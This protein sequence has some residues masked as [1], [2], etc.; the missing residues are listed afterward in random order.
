M[1][2]SRKTTW[3]LF[4]AALVVRLFFVA[5]IGSADVRKFLSN[6]SANYLRG[7]DNLLRYGQFSRSQAL[8]LAPDT[9]STP[10]Y[11]L[12]LAGLQAFFGDA[13]LPVVALQA[14]AGA[15]TAVLAFSLARTL[16]GSFAQSVLAGSFLVVEVVTLLL[17]NLVLTETLFILLLTGALLVL[18]HYSHSL[19]V[20]WLIAGA[21]LLGLAALTRP[22]AQFLPLIFLPLPWLV[23]QPGRRK[24]GH[25][26]L[27][28]GVF[29]AW[30]MPWMLRNAQVADVFALS[31]ISHQ[32]LVAYRAAAVLADA[33]GLS[34]E[35]AAA[36]LMALPE[37]L[38]HS[39]A[40]VMAI[41]QRRAID[42]F[43]QHPGATLKM[44]L[45]GMARLLLDPGFS[46][47]CTLLDRT[48]VST[49]CFAGEG[50]MLAGG[51]LQRVLGRFV[52]LTLFQQFMLA[53]STLI[54]AVLYIGAVL[55]A[56]RL[57]RQR[58]W[59]GLLLLVGTL[60]YFVLLS[61]GAESDYRLR[62]PII[63]ILAALAGIACDLGNR[64]F[65]G[66]F[67]R[68]QVH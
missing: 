55:G 44:T 51:L 58:N 31:T 29:L 53:W 62:A 48:Q 16:G 57:L 22:V 49:E 25:S 21:S 11:P 50:T 1:T 67:H 45:M 38:A 12:T 5:Y 47:V 14:L 32:S 6:D 64:R 56:W 28:L 63:P 54:T 18:A 20:R 19:R 59:F 43:M 17:S 37:N 8:P 9:L 33:E 35:Q 36:Q 65:R 10:L 60:L 4:S 52:T 66:R 7:A 34:N 3:I 13:R 39:P 42:V 26:L 61:S 23:A 2:P 46:P 27:F 30:T 68:T 15:A 41:Q 24:L 40:E